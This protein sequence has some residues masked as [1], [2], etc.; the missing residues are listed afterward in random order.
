MIL[1]KTKTCSMPANH[2]GPIPGIE[3]GM[4]WRFRIQVNYLYHYYLLYLLYY[5]L[6]FSG[7]T[8]F[9]ETEVIFQFLAIS[10]QESDGP[11]S[12]LRSDEWRE[13]R[14]ARLALPSNQPLT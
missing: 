7:L 2:F 10:P 3:V 14:A 12:N 5:C 9:H 1:G 6:K 4:C 11:E 8:N 13:S